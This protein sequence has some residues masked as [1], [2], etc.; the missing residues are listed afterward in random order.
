MELNLTI[1]FCFSL[2]FHI[3][4]K[5]T[6]ANTVMERARFKHTVTYLKKQG[7]KLSQNAMGISD[8]ANFAFH[9]KAVTK[10]MVVE[11]NN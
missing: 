7:K 2:K 9:L 11:A 5:K 4:R 10:A 1:S 8:R 6:K 3:L